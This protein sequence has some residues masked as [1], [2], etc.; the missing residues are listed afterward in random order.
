MKKLVFFTILLTGVLLRVYQLGTIPHGL[1]RDE[2]SI[3]YTA[4]LLRHTLRDEHG[5]FLP[6]KFESFG[7]WK[8]PLYIYLTIPFISLFGL[9][10]VGVRSLAVILGIVLIPATFFLT[11]NLISNVD[12]NRA[13][14]PALASAVFLTVNPWHFHFSRIAHEGILG[15]ALLTV[16]AIFLL[17][18]KRT[19]RK[20]VLGITLLGFS[21]FTY[22]GA[23]V[24][25]PLWFGGFCLLFLKNLTQNRST[26]ITAIIFLTTIFLLLRNA[27]FTGENVKAKGVFIFS[28]T[29]EEKYAAIYSKRTS[30]FLSPF[31]HNQYMYFFKTIIHN[32]FQTFTSR[33]LLTQGGT[34][35]H[36][37]I[38]GFGNFLLPEILFAAIGAVFVFLRGNK[39]QK[40]VLFWFLLAPLG[41]ALTKDGIHSGRQVFMLPSVQV[42][43]GIG[44]Y[45]ISRKIKPTSILLT[46]I[47]LTASFGFPFI[48]FYFGR[49][50]R[51][52]DRLFS[53]DMKPITHFAYKSK[54]QYQKII[55]T[56]PYE[57]PYIFYAF[58]NQVDPGK[59]LNTIHYYPVDDLG[60]RHVQSV[61]NIV[62]VAKN[63]EILNKSR[64]TVENNLIFSR[65]EE[66]PNWIKPLKLWD[67]LEGRQEIVAWE[68]TQL[69]AR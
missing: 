32:Y 13:F 31:L 24:A 5:R 34:H 10:E 53:G 56:F 12:K 27:L 42:L 60:F 35:P 33:F 59:F 64:E 51:I 7:D 63:S 66:I 58:Y 36:Y 55:M 26:R 9:T 11:K 50:S 54:D 14:Y 47:V 3:G 17:S 43:A 57:S 30:S 41:G 38:P 65:I 61:G 67:N 2:A 18:P 62:F 21:L 20:I 39:R 45:A 23:L 6:L 15:V 44:A 22:H 52:S 25:V 1:N 29:N 46:A 19:S 28:L 49:Y 37:N 16:G 69:K 4:Y 8:Q 68:E 48:A 40:M